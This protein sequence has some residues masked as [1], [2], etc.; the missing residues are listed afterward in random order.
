MSKGYFVDSSDKLLNEKDH[1]VDE[2]S[3]QCSRCNSRNLTVHP[4]GIPFR[5][6]PV[7]SSDLP[8]EAMNYFKG[9]PNVAQ[10][11]ML[12]YDK[13][14]DGILVECKNCS[15]TTNDF[16]NGKML[17]VPNKNRLRKYVTETY[18]VNEEFE[19]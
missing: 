8:T 17:A 6:G 1:S 9:V 15:L 2:W 10:A 14:G 19:L 4:V 3:F 13:K 7:G 16:Y 5:Y 12:C 18:N 11:V